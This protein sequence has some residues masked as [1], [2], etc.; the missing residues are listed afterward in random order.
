[1][2]GEYYLVFKQKMD[3]EIVGRQLQRAFICKEKSETRPRKNEIVKYI[4]IKL[5]LVLITFRG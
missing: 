4:K 1:M 3:G 5:N 2:K